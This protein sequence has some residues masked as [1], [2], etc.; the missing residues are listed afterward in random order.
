MSTFINSMHVNNKDKSMWTYIADSDISYHSKNSEMSTFI[1]SM[2]VNNKDK[3]RWTYIA[4]S[5][6]SMKCDSMNHHYSAMQVT[7]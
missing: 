6:I 5:F 4:H 1:N 3:T 2:H 7:Q